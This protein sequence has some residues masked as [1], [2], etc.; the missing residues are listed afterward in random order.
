M[1][2]EVSLRAFCGSLS[3]WMNANGGICRN[4]PVDVAERVKPEL[5]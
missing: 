4:K 2:L 3:L 5:G 1:L